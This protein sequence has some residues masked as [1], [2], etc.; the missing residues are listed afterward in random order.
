MKSTIT[1][2]LTDEQINKIVKSHQPSKPLTYSIR[3]ASRVIGIS[4]ATIRRMIKENF[5]STVIMGVSPRITQKE[6][7]RYV[8]DL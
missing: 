5:I 3:E 6:I 8:N 4:E 2:E 7:D 1:I